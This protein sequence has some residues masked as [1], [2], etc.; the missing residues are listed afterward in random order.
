MFSLSKSSNANGNRSRKNKLLFM[1]I[2]LWQQVAR[3]IEFTKTNKKCTQNL[4]R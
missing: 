1:N 3:Q 2:K 4:K